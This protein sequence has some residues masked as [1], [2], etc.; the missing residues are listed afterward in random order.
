MQVSQQLS[1]PNFF[2]R[3][4]RRQRLIAAGVF[5]GLAAFFGFF[6]LAGR[7]KISPWPFPCGFKQ[8]YHLPCPTCGVTTSVIAFSQGK[9]F[10]SFY[11]QPAA[12]LACCFL[13]IS[14]CFALFIAVSGMYFDFLNSFF[15]KMR[16]KYVIFI[17]IVII[18][19]G[20]AFTLAKALAANAQN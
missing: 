7:Y 11:I 10:E 5:L 2:S 14:A 4:S 16:I 15:S 8:R 18:A 13:V 3:A 6:A 20:W 19:V 17:M 12:A 9:I 1:P